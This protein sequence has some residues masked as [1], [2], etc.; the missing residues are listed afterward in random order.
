MTLKNSCRT[1]GQAVSSSCSS[2]NTDRN[3]MSNV[4]NISKTALYNRHINTNH[5]SHTL[6]LRT[7]QTSK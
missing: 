1:V 7:N 2:D 5:D 4:A 6:N 3:D